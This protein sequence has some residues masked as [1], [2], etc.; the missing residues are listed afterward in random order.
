MNIEKQ[1]ARMES[2]GLKIMR[3]KIHSEGNFAQLFVAGGPILNVYRGERTKLQGQNLELMQN[4]FPDNFDVS[5]TIAEYMVK[6]AGSRTRY[7]IVAATDNPFT[8]RDLTKAIRNLT[9]KFGIT[10]ERVY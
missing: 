9:D 7:E 8:C 10:C 4:V 6:R 2:R 5:R 3:T 1:K